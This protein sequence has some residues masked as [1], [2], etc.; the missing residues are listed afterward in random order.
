[1]R[2]LIC[3]FGSHGDVLPLIAIG[4]EL[5]RR[6]HEVIVG[7]AEPFGE[8][9]RRA[10]LDFEQLATAAEYRE[11]LD[12]TDLW[13]P[14]RGVRRLFGYVER[15]IGPVFDFIA[16]RRLR[17]RT[18]V[19][20]SSLA[21][22]ARVAHDAIRTPLVTVHLSPLM[23]Q[24]RHEAPRLPGVPALAW[25]PPRYKWMFHMGVDERFVDPILTPQLNRFRAELGLKPIKRLRHW[26]NAPKRVLLM[27]PDWFA[28][29]QED[30]PAQ[31]RR[32]GFPRADVF[33]RP[34]D[35]PDEALAAFLAD[36]D[37]PVAVTFGSALTGGAGLYRA[38]IDACARL[39]RRCLVLSPYEI[40]VP[41]AMRASTF[42][43]AYAPFGDVLPTCA[44]FVHHGGVGTLA[45]GFAAGIPQLV[46]PLAFDQFDNAAR[47]K[48]LGC[49]A[50]IGRHLFSGR[51]GARALSALL[52]SPEVAQKCR[53]VANLSAESDAVSRACDEIEAEFAAG[54]EARR[55]RRAS[56]RTRRAPA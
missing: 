43:A 30:W 54:V 39:K 21:I 7:S 40:E 11:A 47:L 37:P 15:S 24:S 53:R 12:Q 35:R 5:K 38:A 22:G 29:P 10:G 18:M 55:A 17:G 16:R 49:G 46:V 27:W 8:A 32:I 6:G 19:I 33:G 45:Q 41:A 26:W 3:A 56:D 31:A 25:L 2:A 14:I 48:R 42:V 13:R 20:A 34:D 4:A 50:H 44:A 51:R 36:G 9:A 23:M 1:M 28:A 52:A